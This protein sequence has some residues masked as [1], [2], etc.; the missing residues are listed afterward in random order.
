MGATVEDRRR[1]STIVEVEVAPSQN[2]DFDDS[3][4]SRTI[5]VK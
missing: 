4:T 5:F 2:C 1:F 3:S